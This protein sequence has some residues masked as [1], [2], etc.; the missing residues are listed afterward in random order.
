MSSASLDAVA[1]YTKKWLSKERFTQR[2]AQ[3]FTKQQIIYHRGRHGID[4]IKENSLPAMYRAV[5]DGATMIEFDV[6]E[7]LK[8]SHDPNSNPNTPRLPQILRAIN[9]ACDVNI[10]IKSPRMATDVLA[11]IYE[12]LGGNLSR[13]QMNQFVISSFHHKTAAWFKAHEPMLRVG[14]IFDG[15]LDAL[16][17]ERLKERGINTLH[18]DWMNA[19]MD[20]E[21]GHD[22]LDTSRML[23]MPIWAWTV[24]DLPTAQAMYTYGAER[25]F[26]DKP[27]L[28]V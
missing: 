28:F 21:G 9:G 1:L 14:A 12:A 2:R 27:E 6:W 17:I 16:Y 19:L 26:T 25:I 20:K 24:N 3:M 8:V 15:V 4:G 13:W 23:Q 22:L 7:D 18:I 5:A 10:E 11:T